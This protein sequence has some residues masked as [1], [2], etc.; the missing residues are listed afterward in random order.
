MGKQSEH[1]RLCGQAVGR[2][3]LARQIEALAGEC[4]ATT[5][6]RPAY[7]GHKRAI[8]LLISK[9]E[10]RCAIDLDGDSRVGA[11]LGHWYS[12]DHDSAATLPDGFAGAIRSSVNPHHRRKATTCE[13]SFE[14]FLASLRGGLNAIDNG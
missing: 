3:R 11:F 2:E 7:L 4:G 9:G 6:R 1:K 13:D 8:L 5:E 10:W 12:D 14:G